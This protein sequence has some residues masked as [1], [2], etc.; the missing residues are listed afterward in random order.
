[1]RDLTVPQLIAIQLQLNSPSV[2]PAPDTAYKAANNFGPLP[3]ALDSEKWS[4]AEF[5]SRSFPYCPLPDKPPASVKAEDWDA[6][7]K[8]LL[9]NKFIHRSSL[10]TLDMVKTWLTVSVPPY[11]QPP[12]DTPTEGRHLIPPEQVQMVNKQLITLT[13]P[14]EKFSN[15]SGPG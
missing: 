9:T 14:N 7:V 2:V 8:Y 15:I 1:M 12:G 3:T 5:L 6:R 4:P 10:P 11:L 13:T